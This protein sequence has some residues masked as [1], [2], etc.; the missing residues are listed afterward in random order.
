MRVDTKKILE[1]IESAR[2]AFHERKELSSYIKENAFHLRIVF[3]KLSFPFPIPS[4][5]SAL[6][7]NGETIACRCGHIFILGDESSDTTPGNEASMARGRD[8]QESPKLACDLLAKSITF[9]SADRDDFDL[10]VERLYY[11]LQIGTLFRFGMMQFQFWVIKYLIMSL[12]MMSPGPEVA[13]DKTLWSY[14]LLG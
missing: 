1:Q 2:Q 3:E 14:F 9:S 11:R 6:P 10:L 8:M 5:P 12:G 4:L 13:T 7:A